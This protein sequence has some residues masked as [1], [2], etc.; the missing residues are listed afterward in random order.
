[1]Y[2]NNPINIY[3]YSSIFSIRW[4]TFHKMWKEGGCEV[5]TNVG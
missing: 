1:M 2:N 3:I 4:N 5:P